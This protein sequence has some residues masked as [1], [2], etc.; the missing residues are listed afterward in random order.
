ML[1]HMFV[2]KEDIIDGLPT[3]CYIVG[4]SVEN[5]NYVP[6]VSL[7]RGDIDYMVWKLEQYKGDFTK[8]KV[9]M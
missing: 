1:V 9:K 3:A 6:L 8:C 4:K 7:T 5:T 2:A